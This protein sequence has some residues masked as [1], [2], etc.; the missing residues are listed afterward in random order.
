M[1]QFTGKFTSMFSDQ[2]EVGEFIAS[3]GEGSMKNAMKFQHDVA[4]V[5]AFSLSLSLCMYLCVCQRERESN[6]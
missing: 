1:E 4:E 6:H 3:T 5:Q 2:D